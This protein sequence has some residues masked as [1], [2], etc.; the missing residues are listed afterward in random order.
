[1]E[2]RKNAR[3]R[4]IY[5]NQKGGAGRRGIGWEFNYPQ[6]IKKWK[7][8]GHWGKRGRREREYV[9]AR[10]GDTGPYSYENTKII[11]QAE[12]LSEGNVGHTRWV[13]RKH[14][15]ET[16]RKLSESHM[17]HRPSN[18]TRTKMRKSQSA[19]RRMEQLSRGLA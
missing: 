19:R 15:K 4:S 16:L 9:M 14:T 7:E 1:M 11:T 10:Y 3:V 13:G 5:L 18:E 12:N 6:W 2:A 8:S 17:G